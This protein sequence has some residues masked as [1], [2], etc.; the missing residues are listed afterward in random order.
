MC[1]RICRNCQHWG[2]QWMSV[3]GYKERNKFVQNDYWMNH[4]DE[5]KLYITNDR[6]TTNTAWDCRVIQGAIEVEI[7]QGSGY[8]AGGASVEEICTPGDF[9]C[10]KFQQWDG[11]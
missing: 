7:D 1:D 3:S 6:A 5:L 4:L 2:N 11:A 10:I 8:D 9:G